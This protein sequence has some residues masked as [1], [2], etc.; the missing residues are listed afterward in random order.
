MWVSR[1]HAN[2]TIRPCRAPKP[3]TSH[4]RAH[5]RV[6]GEDGRRGLRSRG[7]AAR[8]ADDAKTLAVPRHRR[9]VRDLTPRTGWRSTSTVRRFTLPPRRSWT[10]GST[11]TCCSVRP[12]SHGC[13][14]HCRRWAA[15]R[16]QARSRPVSAAKSAVSRLASDSRSAWRR[17]ARA[18][19]PSIESGLGAATIWIMP[20][21]RPTRSLVAGSRCGAASV[22]S[23]GAGRSWSRTAGRAGDAARLAAPSGGGPAA[24]RPRMCGRRPGLPR[25]PP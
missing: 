2:W 6:G 21:P 18:R 4:T 15:D 20:S 11:R 25:P 5:P 13:R 1:S 10:S 3:R 16:M 23:G 22:V 17:C 7:R 8:G 19:G 24:G 14:S 12:R 9:A